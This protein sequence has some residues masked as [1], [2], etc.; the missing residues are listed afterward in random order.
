[1]PMKK[2]MVLIV[3]SL[4][5]AQAN[6]QT[7]IFNDLLQEHVTADGFVDYTSFNK[8]KLERYLSYLERTSPEVTWSENKQKAFWIN[9]YNAYTIKKILEYDA[10]I[11]IVN[12]KENN[13]TAWK[14]P[15]AKVGG[16]TYTLDY[17][18]HEIL[19]KNLF[20][21][22]IHVGVNCASNSCPKLG[23]IAFTEENIEATLE[24]LMKVF[25]NDSTKNKITKNKLQIS[26][27]FDWFQEDFIKNGTVIEYLN[28]YSKTTINKKIAIHYLKYDWSLNGK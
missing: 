5:F 12:I 17:I 21:P 27:I 28:T 1:M 23:N 24:K 8:E 3:A 9:A 20:D 16:K 11:S 4:T 14:I 26:S 10:L 13:Q 2:L 15:F 22:R 6:A 18:E 7:A 19:R 25:I